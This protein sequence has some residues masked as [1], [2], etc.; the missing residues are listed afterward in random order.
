MDG[1]GMVHIHIVDTVGWLKPHVVVAWVC[2]FAEVARRGLHH[3]SLK[4]KSQ[5]RSNLVLTYQ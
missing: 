1:V 4:A 3:H 2:I 5:N